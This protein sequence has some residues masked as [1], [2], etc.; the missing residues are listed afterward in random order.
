MLVGMRVEHGP[1]GVCQVVFDRPGTLNAVGPETLE[2]LTRVLTIL[3]DDRTV[4]ALILTGA[5]GGFCSG[6]DLNM[7]EGFA[8]KSEIEVAATLRHTMRVSALLRA[9]P[10]PT[11]AVVGGPAAGAGM[12]FALSCDVRIAS[13]TA[14][15]LPSFI[16]MG[17]VPD[18]GLSWLLPR[19]IGDGAALEMLVAGRPVAAGRAAELG[20]FTRVCDDPMAAALELATMFAARPPRAVAATKRLLRAAATSSLEGAIDAEAL[21]QAAAFHR[22]EFADSVAGWRSG[23]HAD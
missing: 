5:G 10:Q 2:C 19:L 11:I 4:R 22:A 15:L 1:D 9:L 6:A 17:L 3:G 16:R 23:R 7:I 14:V 12:S 13:P 20:L 18:C 21:A 8:E